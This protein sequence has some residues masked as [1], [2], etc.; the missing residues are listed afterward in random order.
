MNPRA[1]GSFH[2]C[3]ENGISVKVPPEVRAGFL[4]V[5]EAYLAPLA[6]QISQDAQERPVVDIQVLDVGR[7]DP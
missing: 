2:A 3:E 5:D 4:R 6:H 7:T 1:Q